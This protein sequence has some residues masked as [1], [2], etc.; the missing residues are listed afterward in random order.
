MPL[1]AGAVR[2][3]IARA[4]FALSSLFRFFG[5]MIITKEK[6]IV[7]DALT[8]PGWFILDEMMIQQVALSDHHMLKNGFEWRYWPMP[9]EW[10]RQMY[11]LKNAAKKVKG[12]K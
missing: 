1:R 11:G 9:E 10:C 4:C 5:K 3:R 7:C 8:L 12:D 6:S 2:L